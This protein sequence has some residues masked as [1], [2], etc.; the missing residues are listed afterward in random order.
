M[1]ISRVVLDQG[2]E[3]G[4]RALDR[5]AHGG[6]DAWQH[7]RR[8]GDRR[9]RHEVRVAPGPVERVADGDRQSGL[10]DS[11]GARERH[12]PHVGRLEQ[13]RQ[14]GDGALP[15]EQ[16][17]R[18]C[19]QRATRWP[20]LGG[21]RRRRR[22]GGRGRRR[23]PLAEEQGQV[24][25]HEPAE[26][27]CAA[28][29]PVGVGTLGLE[30]SDHRRQPGLLLRGGHLEVEQARHPLGQPELVLEP[31]DVH[32]GPDPP[33]ALP[34][35]ADEHVR[36][37]QVRPVELTRRVWSGPELEDHRRQPERRD[38][39]GDRSPLRG[40]LGQRRADEDAQPLVGCPDRRR[41]LVVSRHRGSS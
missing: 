26:L 17:G 6:R 7:E 13:G 18:R 15:T 40:E 33:V 32:P 8:I 21:R 36:L 10:A 22:R 25:A 35:Q 31:R 14:L 11:A 27:A 30:V 34:V 41:H 20:D 24:V 16:R 29:G 9:E 38:R 3:G 4:A 19:R 12:Q 39:P 5:H 28:E 2:V 37:R 23:E 1:G